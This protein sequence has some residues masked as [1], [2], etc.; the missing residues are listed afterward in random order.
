MTT[1]K[2]AKGDTVTIAATVDAVEY[3][4]GLRLVTVG[5]NWSLKVDQ[6]AAQDV[7]V[8]KKA[9]P[10][11]PKAGSVVKLFDKYG[12]DA[13]KYIVQ[14]DGSLFSINMSTG[15]VYDAYEKWDRLDFSYYTATVLG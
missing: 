13:G 5:N 2:P 3:N 14:K 12:N 15:A 6:W 11:L 9:A 7:K 10:E 8:T 4:G 1:T